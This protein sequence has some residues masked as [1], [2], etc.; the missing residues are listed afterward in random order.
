MIHW[1]YLRTDCWGQTVQ[2]FAKITL[3]AL[4]VNETW[5]RTAGGMMLTGKN[6]GTRRKPIPL[7]ISLRQIPNWMVWNQIRTSDVSVLR[8]ESKMEEET[9]GWWTELR[10]GKVSREEKLKLWKRKRRKAPQSNSM[11]QSP[12]WEADR[13]SDRQEAL[14]SYK[15]Y[16]FIT[17]LTTARQLYLS[18][19]RSIQSY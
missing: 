10:H 14:A 1:R 11:Q 4:M 7:P 12:A 18:Q 3:T 13:S 15:T 5:V 6:R 9:D 8:L 2:S 16:R 19:G 17:V